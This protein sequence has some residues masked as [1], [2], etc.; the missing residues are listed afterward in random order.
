VSH[1][2]N[3]ANLPKTR[4]IWEMP[5]KGDSRK[6]RV[7]TFMIRTG[8]NSCQICIQALPAAVG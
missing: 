2:P 3:T 1:L 8:G 7:L 6:I 4:G 5:D